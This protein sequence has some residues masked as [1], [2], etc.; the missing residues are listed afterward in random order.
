MRDKYL[1]GGTGTYKRSKDYSTWTKTSGGNPGIE[2]VFLAN[3]NG[4]FA[5]EAKLDATQW[6]NVTD[7]SK[8]KEV[9][10]QIS[11]SVYAKFKDDFDFIFFVLN[12]EDYAIGNALGFA[13]THIRVSN[14]VTG[15]GI[16]EYSNAPIY[17]SDEKLKSLMY[18]PSYDSILLGPALHEIA[19]KWAAYICPTYTMGNT[20]DVRY[21]GHW[22]ISN[23]G[24]Q[25][26]GF[27]YV[28][29]IS[30][31]GG[32]TEY[33]GSM[34]GTF[35][36]GFGSNANGGNGLVYSDIELYT[37]GMIGADE[38]K[39]KGFQLDIYSGLSPSDKNSVEEKRYGYFKAT[40]IKSYTIDDLI[41][42]NGPR[43]PDASA[44]QKS[45]KVLTVILS[46]NQDTTASTRYDK[47]V[48]DVKWLAG[49]HQ[50]T[51]NWKVY[52]FK[53]ATGGKGSLI[54]GDIKKSL[55]P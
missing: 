37:M 11:I 43:V 17:G 36:D 44:S 55:K 35:T 1:A 39:R 31:S 51:D 4:D 42:L 21:D 54:V 40:T 2:L 33:Q 22:G 27:K 47:I 10:Q 6:A 19:H 34:D 16:E 3:D 50:D 48:K 8:Y 52:N 24:G 23:A 9:L 13:G 49:L 18:F 41:S 53:E 29:T 28:K 15:L 25:L 14:S 32:T 38:L 26:G 46:N 45:F 7:R 30:T 5:V 12:T 20:G